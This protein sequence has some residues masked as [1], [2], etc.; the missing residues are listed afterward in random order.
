[1][2][3]AIVQ[4]VPSHFPHFPA[5]AFICS[6]PLSHIYPVIASTSLPLS[7]MR[8]AVAS[9]SLLLPSYFP[10]SCPTRTQLLPPLPCSC[11]HMCPVL[12]PYVPSRCPHFPAPAFICTLPLFQMRSAI[13]ST[14]MLLP[15]Y[16]SWPCPT[17][18]QSLPHF[19]ALALMCALPVSHINPV[20]ASTSLLLHLYVSWPCPTRTQSLPP[21]PS[22]CLHMC[23]ALVPHV[24]SHCLHCPALAFICALPLSHTYPDTAFTSLLLPSYV[25][26]PC[27]TC[28]LPLSPL[29]CICLH[30]CPAL[31]PHVSCHCPHFP[32][33]AFICALP[34]FHM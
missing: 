14:S 21:L 31:V 34:L 3:P 29:P 32:A 13:A 11:L 30:M 23:P 20:I 26:C 27:P 22:S 19:P 24:P 12:V 7:Q 17:R 4:R 8:P 16:V 15:S 5:L 2:C 6:L 10:C 9:T 25:P 33:L 28:V 1:M 18:T